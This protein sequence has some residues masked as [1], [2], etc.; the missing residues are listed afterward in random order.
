MDLYKGNLFLTF[1]LHC[2][3]CFGIHV[4]CYVQSKLPRRRVL[5]NRKGC[6]LWKDILK[7]NIRSGETKLLD[8]HQRKIWRNG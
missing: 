6:V 4:W 7:R 3:A 5:L 8:C 1:I 2:S